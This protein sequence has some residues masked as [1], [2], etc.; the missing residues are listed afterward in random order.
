MSE[1]TSLVN[2]NLV[3]PLVFIAVCI[4][5]FAIICVVIY[6]SLLRHIIPEKIATLLGFL[7]SVAILYECSEH[8][9]W[10]KGFVR[11]F[12]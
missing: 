10:I 2:E 1:L 11:Q 7:G 5:L 4:F 8:F 6:Y 9:E 12:I 3:G